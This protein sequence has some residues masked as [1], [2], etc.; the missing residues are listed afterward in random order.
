MVGVKGQKR[1]QVWHNPLLWRPRD[2]PNGRIAIDVIINH[3]WFIPERQYGLATRTSPGVG[4]ESYDSEAGGRQAPSTGA[5]D[6]AAVFAAH[7]A[8]QTM[9]MITASTDPPQ[10]G[11]PAGGSQSSWVNL[12]Q[13]TPQDRQR[14]ADALQKSDPWAAAAANLPPHP[15]GR[16]RSFGPQR[17]PSNS[18]PA[19][20][21]PLGGETP[22]TRYGTPSSAFGIREA[23]LRRRMQE[24]RIDPSPVE[25]LRAVVA[26]P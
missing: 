18:G 20:F 15:G 8:G 23:D 1:G 12:E 26:M 7:H 24:L 4:Y 25:A 3:G 19:R 16:P 14:M 13:L 6:R 5:S 9:F 11:T 22:P 10:A 21:E 2:Y 17:P